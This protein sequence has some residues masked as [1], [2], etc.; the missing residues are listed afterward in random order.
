MQ[1]VYQKAS[2]GVLVILAAAAGGWL[3]APRGSVSAQQAAAYRQA[4]APRQSTATSSALVT[5][6]DS[7]G[8]EPLLTVVDSASHVISVYHIDSASGEI[9]LR[10]VRNFHYDLQ[11]DEFNGVSPTPQEIRSLLQR[12]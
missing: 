3:A 7:A 12:R 8:G 5:H 4:S 11:M 10:G 6:Y 9:T 1:K 2:W